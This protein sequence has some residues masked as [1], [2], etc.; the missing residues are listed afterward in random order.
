MRGLLRPGIR[1]IPGFCFTPGRPL[2]HQP[3]AEK[4]T[5]KQNCGKE[6]SAIMVSGHTGWT[7]CQTKVE[8][9]RQL[10]LDW[11]LFWFELV[12]FT[13]IRYK[14]Y[15]SGIRYMVLP[16]LLSRSNQGILEPGHLSFSFP[17]PPCYPG[18]DLFYSSFHFQLKH[19]FIQIETV[20]RIAIK[21]SRMNENRPI[22]TETKYKRY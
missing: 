15:V 5:T 1:L 13:D 2:H 10:V 9:Q 16:A 19:W 4:L 12:K 7:F 20:F 22:H 6:T 8:G 11:K 17:S 3:A 18:D 21:A 14:V